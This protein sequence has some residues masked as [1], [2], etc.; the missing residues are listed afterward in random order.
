MQKI[1]TLKPNDPDVKYYTP[2]VKSVNGRFFH[3]D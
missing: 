3:D 1:L 2:F